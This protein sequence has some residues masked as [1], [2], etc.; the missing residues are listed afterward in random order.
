MSTIAYVRATSI[1]NDSRALKEIK[2]IA[3]AGY[4]VN[5]LGWDRNGDAFEKC[6]RS[7][8]NPKIKFKFFD[9]RLPDGIG[10]KN[11][12]KLFRWVKWE[13]GQLNGIGI[14][15]AVHACD[16]D[17]GIGAYSFCKKSDV[18]L[19]YDIYDYYIDSHV[20]P[21]LIE[22]IVENIE[23]RIINYAKCTI[24]CTDERI[25]QIKKA[26]PKKV[27]VIH[28]SP[29][30]GEIE[31]IPLEYDYV[32]CGCLDGRRLI[33]EILEEYPSHNDLK[34]CFAGFGSNS[35]SARLLSETYDNFKYSGPVSYDE[36]I[37]IEKRSKCISA[38]YDPSYRNHRLCAPNKFY[39]A[40]AL[41][42]PIIAC[43]GTGI[44]KVIEQHKMGIV[45]DYNTK[46]FYKAIEILTLN[47]KLGADM[48]KRGRKLYEE[49]YRW[50]IMKDRL[51]SAYNELIP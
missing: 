51:L 22:T 21:S 33:Q 30:V 42:K 23:I 50:G 44:D 37:D 3:E 31:N 47:L 36:V 16:L 35:V 4:N 14:L 11:I 48:G 40:M 6:K 25:E 26:K 19:I 28:N 27:I 20:V 2:A 29:D 17:A 46:E 24:I 38:I 10:I 12:D 9:V 1:Y 43:R 49:K 41:G 45:I 34:F 7:F 5:V 15:E 39:E 8:S 13:K 18:P 32:Y